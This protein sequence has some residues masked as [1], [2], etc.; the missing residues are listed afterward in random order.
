MRNAERK[1]FI[2]Q[3]KFG[4]TSGNEKSFISFFESQMIHKLNKEQKKKTSQ[5]Q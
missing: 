2:N 3:L 1:R 4:K 5:K